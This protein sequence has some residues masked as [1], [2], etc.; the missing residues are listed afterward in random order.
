MT[1]GLTSGKLAGAAGVNVETI[2]Y[3]EMIGLMPRVPRTGGG[4]RIYD[5]S[6]VRQLAFIRRS[7]ELGFGIDEIRALLA[8]SAPDRRSCDKVQDI[9]ARHLAEVRAKRA[10]LARL[11]AILADTIARCSGKKAAPCPVLDMLDAG[12]RQ[13]VTPREP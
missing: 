13:G 5:E 11:E 3:Y 8:L 12:S 10:D 2:R 7:R 6:H 4:R 9:A 1:R